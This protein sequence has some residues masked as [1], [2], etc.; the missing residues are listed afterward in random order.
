MFAKKPQL[1]FILLF[2]KI[3][4]EF[5]KIN[6]E[7]KINVGHQTSADSIANSRV[8]KTRLQVKKCD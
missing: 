4:E 7:N 1:A 5:N 2:R 8:N 6:Q 3:Y